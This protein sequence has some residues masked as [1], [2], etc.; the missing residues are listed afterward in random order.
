MR[1]SSCDYT[2]IIALKQT[3]TNHAILVSREL[4]SILRDVNN[5]HEVSGYEFDN[6]SYI[7][8][9]SDTVV[10]IENLCSSDKIKDMLT[11]KQGLYSW[12]TEDIQVVV[13]TVDNESLT[14]FYFLWRLG[15]NDI[16]PRL[17]AD[18]NFKKSDIQ[19]I[20]C[21]LKGKHFTV[22]SYISKLKEKSKVEENSHRNKQLDSSV[23]AILP[24]KSEYIHCKCLVNS[25][26]LEL[27]SKYNVI[28]F[29]KLLLETLE[30]RVC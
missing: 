17:L 11:N 26:H 29:L 1:K 12:E 19:K 3:A 24:A 23:K 30:N 21:G 28:K 20:Y 13:Y 6:V 15:E 22:T 25:L 10:D 18:C 5:A 2:C 7:T 8:F 27:L 9:T 14:S 4:H 16:S